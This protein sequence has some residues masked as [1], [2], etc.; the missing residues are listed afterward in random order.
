MW[1]VGSCK[2]YFRSA[3]RVDRK[4][5]NYREQQIDHL[6]KAMEPLIWEAYLDLQVYQGP[7]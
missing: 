7:T 4:E 6:T 1:C 3:G 2:V 5:F